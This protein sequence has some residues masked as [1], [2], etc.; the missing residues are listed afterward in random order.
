[1]IDVQAIVSM[2]CQFVHEII[3]VIIALGVLV[4]L[5]L[6]I[7]LLFFLITFKILI[8]DF[9]KSEHHAVPR[10]TRKYDEQV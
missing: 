7:V 10:Y 1:M 5:A 9:E 3:F 6:L 2:L 8:D 4:I